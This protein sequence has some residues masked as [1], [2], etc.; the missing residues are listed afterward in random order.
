MFE[1][2]FT[3]EA[4]DKLRPMMQ[5]TIDSLLDTIIQKGCYEPVDLIR[6]FAESIP[7]Q[8]HQKRDAILDMTR[9]IDQLYRSFTGS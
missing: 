1:A 8:V 4:V 2:F 7:I 6:N 5:K 3:P 9:W